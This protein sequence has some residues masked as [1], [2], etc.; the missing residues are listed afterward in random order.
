LNVKIDYIIMN[1]GIGLIFYSVLLF[2]IIIIKL[3][4]KIKEVT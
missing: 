3:N 2:Y 4:L 1:L